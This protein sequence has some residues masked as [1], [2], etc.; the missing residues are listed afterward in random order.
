MR[1]K[2]L[3]GAFLGVSLG[4][5]SQG[6]GI[7]EILNRVEKGNTGVLVQ[8]LEVKIKEKNEKKAFRNL[9]LPPIEISSENDWEI[10]KKEGLGFEEVEAYIPIFQGGKIL[11]SYKR[12]KTDLQLSRVN[13]NVILYKEQESSI[14][15]YFEYL[16][17]KK[18]K[19][20]TMGTIKALEKQKSRLAG[21]YREGKMIPKSEV[22]KVEANIE[23]NKAINMENI[24]KERSSKENL[25][26]LLGYSLDE[27][28]DLNDF[29]SVKYLKS[30]ENTEKKERPQ[31]TSLGKVEEY[32][33]D[34]AEYDVKIA[35]GDLYPTLY[36]K[37]SHEFRRENT[38][39]KSYD[40]VNEGRVEVGFRYIF[41]WGATLDNISQKEYQLDQ[42]KLKYTNNIKG[43]DLSMRNKLREIESLKGQS[44]AQKKRVDLLDENLKIDTLRYANEL[45]TTFD[46]LNSVNQT[47]TAQEDYYEL[48]RKLVLS[49][50]EYNNLYK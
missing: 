39:T 38:T 50:V 6:I 46:Y 27:N 18:Q 33:V 30:I 43:I 37:P 9:I 11:N 34:L 35:K 26:Q 32:K 7:E 22:L 23:N 15:E 4:I 8:D 36:I 2:F 17:Y 29:D 40:N 5:Y 3:M 44:V 10:A 20:I 16:N 28:I 14:G 31:D 41:S 47:R 24:Q 48:Q 19:D 49:V 45:V 1:K 42:S 12:S 21:L 13:K 25:M